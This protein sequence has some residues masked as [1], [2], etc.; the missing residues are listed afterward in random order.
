MNAAIGKVETIMRLGP[1]IPVVTISDQRH[2]VP[3]AQALVEGGVRVI[4]VTLR[5][6]IALEALRL[7]AT[8]VPDAIAGAGTI[9]EPGQIH[10]ALTAGARFLVSPGATG[11][12][13]AEAMRSGAPLLPGAA[14]ASEAMRLLAA[15]FAY[16]K[17]FPA[18]AAGGTALLSALAA[19]LPQIR[20]CPTGGISAQEAPLY[21]RL[22]NVLCVGGSW[23]TPADAVAAGDWGRIRALA[24]ATGNLRPPATV[25]DGAKV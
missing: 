13:I 5:T 12:L 9:I 23:L 8:E 18:A 16:Q 4:E 22:R 19:P 17:F 2:A 1:V 21:L 7:I 3:L 25:V 10:A 24:L 6:P 14:T 11:E 20:F 15:G